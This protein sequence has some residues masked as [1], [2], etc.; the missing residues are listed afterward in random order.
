MSP[1]RQQTESRNRMTL[2][3]RCSDFEMETLI[4]IDSRVKSAA[5]A[6]RIRLL[7]TSRLASSIV[8]S[9]LARS[10]TPTKFSQ[11]SNIMDDRGEAKM[12]K[13]AE[14]RKRGHEV[15][16]AREGFEALCVLRG[17]VPEVLIA[18]LD[19]PRM[20]G[21]ELL[22]VVR[23]RFPQIAVIATSGAYTAHSLPIETTADAITFQQLLEE[24][25]DKEKM[26]YI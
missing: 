6:Q 19:L 22:S 3:V 12:P 23:T 16:M 18:E 13:S 8:L 4:A 24:G 2:R 21:F 15:L 11:H 17:A 26:Y 14:L 10:C 5:V 1:E 20:S 7:S 9:D 25:D